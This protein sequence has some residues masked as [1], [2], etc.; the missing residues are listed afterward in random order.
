VDE[1]GRLA[2]PNAGVRRTGG[3]AQ[4]ND[5][6]GE[7]AGEGGKGECEDHS[8]AFRSLYLHPNAQKRALFRAS[9]KRNLNPCV[10]QGQSR[11]NLLQLVIAH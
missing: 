1:I 3:V 8:E 5:R 6:R 9:G 7:N 4:I 2:A 11:P 10:Q